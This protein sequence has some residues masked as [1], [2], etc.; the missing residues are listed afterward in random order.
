MVGLQRRGVRVDI[1]AADRVLRHVGGVRVRVRMSGI[2]RM[3]GRG[4]GV[5]M[6]TAAAGGALAGRVGRMPL[7]RVV[8]ILIRHDVLLIPP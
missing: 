3:G 1:H 2:V 4:G 8:V 7:P 6:M 5:M